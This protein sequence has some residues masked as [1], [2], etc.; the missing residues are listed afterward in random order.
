MLILNQGRVYL[1]SIYEEKLLNLIADLPVQV[2]RLPVT[3]FTRLLKES[4]GLSESDLKDQGRLI[5]TPWIERL[6]QEAMGTWFGFVL[7]STPV[8]ALE[9]V[10]K[11]GLVMP[12]KSTYFYPKILTGT[13]FFEI[14]PQKSPPC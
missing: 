5:Y 8:L 2:N 4:F 10:A 7:P 1:F 3:I 13:V 6:F 11:A 12:H 14:N 9:E